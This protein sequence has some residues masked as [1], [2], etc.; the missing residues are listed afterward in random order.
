MQTQHPDIMERYGALIRPLSPGAKRRLK[1]HRA[2]SVWHTARTQSEQTDSQLERMLALHPSV[3]HSLAGCAV[4]GCCVPNISLSSHRPSTPHGSDHIL[5]LPHWDSTHPTLMLYADKRFNNRIEDGRVWFQPV[6]DRPD[7]YLVCCA[8]DEDNDFLLQH[9]TRVGH[10]RMAQPCISCGDLPPG[11]RLRHYG[12][13]P[14]CS[15]C[16]ERCGSDTSDGWESQ[17]SRRTTRRTATEMQCSQRRTRTRSR[18]L[19]IACE[20]RGARTL[21]TFGCLLC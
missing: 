14:S 21:R 15:T 8:E 5:D 4:Y 20:R 11:T 1:Q 12:P 19:A 2:G 9:C 6:P 3:S 10:R 7:D 13:R 18:G 16:T 17:R